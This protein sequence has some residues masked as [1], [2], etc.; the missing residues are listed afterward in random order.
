MIAH[1]CSEWDV[2]DGCE[3]LY[4]AMEDC[5]L[6]SPTTEQRSLSCTDVDFAGESLQTCSFS[7]PGV[8]PQE[9]RLCEEGQQHPNPG[10]LSAVQTRA[11]ETEENSRLKAALAIATTVEMSLREQLSRQMEEINELKEKL[12]EITKQSEEGSK[13]IG[14]QSKRINCLIAEVNKFKRKWQL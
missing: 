11:E 4:R 8:C 6:S 10:D 7:A 14:A 5:T 1:A 13:I 12:I 9:A 2:I 3:A